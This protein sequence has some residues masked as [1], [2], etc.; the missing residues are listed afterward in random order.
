MAPGAPMGTHHMREYRATWSSSE[1]RGAIITLKI[2]RGLTE[3]N[4][5]RR[6]ENHTSHY[7]ETEKKKRKHKIDGPNPKV[8]I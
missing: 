8:C 4:I 2:E 1:S 5:R 6:H 7:I 3:R